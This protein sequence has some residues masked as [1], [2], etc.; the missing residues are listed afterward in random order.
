MIWLF[1]I[2]LVIVLIIAA[3]CIK[4]V[5]QSQAYILERLGV[6]KAT[7][8]SGVHFKVPFIERVAKR[9]NLK[10]QVVDFAPQPFI[11]KYNVTMIIDTVL[12]FQI[13]EPRLFTYVIDNPIMAIENLT[14]TTLRD[15]IVW[16][17]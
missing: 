4:I 5:P 15:I 3:S 14:A 7:W 13:T 10:E 16:H 1:I 12:F 17:F 9:V 11:T 8:G 2:L 6:Y